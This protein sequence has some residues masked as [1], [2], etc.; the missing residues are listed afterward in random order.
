MA[1]SYAS[2]EPGVTIPQDT[3]DL[4]PPKKIVCN[5]KMAKISPNL[6]NA[7]VQLR[8][9]AGDYWIDALCINQTYVPKF[10]F[11]LQGL[12]LPFVYPAPCKC[13]SVDW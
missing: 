10:S 12:N 1:K 3:G 11:L 9:R 7:L 4:K 13:S 5:G 6:Y 2:G 8:K